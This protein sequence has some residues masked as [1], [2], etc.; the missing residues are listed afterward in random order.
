MSE[1]LQRNRNDSQDEI[2]WQTVK[3][4]PNFTHGAN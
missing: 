1:L 2:F 3:L 4:A